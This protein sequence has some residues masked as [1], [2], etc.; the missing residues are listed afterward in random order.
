MATDDASIAARLRTRYERLAAFREP[1]LAAWREVARFAAPQADAGRFGGDPQSPRLTGDAEVVE[2]AAAFAAQRL[3]AF[4]ADTVAPYG[5]RWHELRPVGDGAESGPALQAWLDEV[6]DLLFRLRED[7]LAGFQ[8]ALESVLLDLVLYGTAVL[9]VAHEPGLGPRYEPVPVGEVVLG[10]DRAGR[11]DV[12]FRE[13]RLPARELEAAFGTVPERWRAKV[14]TAPDEPVRVLHAVVPAEPGSRWRW[15]SYHLLEG[16]IVRAAGYDTMP[17]CVVRMWLSSGEIYGRGPGILALRNMKR[18]NRVARDMVILANRQAQPPLLAVD[19]D[20]ALSLEPDALNY[21]WL[22][23]ATGR[24]RVLPL[25]LGGS[26]QVA[27][28]MHERDLRAIEEHFLLSL[29]LMAQDKA[30]T[31]TEVVQRAQERGVMLGPVVGRIQQELL[32]PMIV[33]ELAIAE[34]EGFVPPPPPGVALPPLAI[35]YETPALRQM[36]AQDGLAVVRALD[37]IA[38]IARLDPSALAAL[39]LPRAARVIAES[40]GVP[41]SVLRDEKEVRRA[42]EA[43]T[44]GALAGGGAA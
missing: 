34:A 7:P 22:D 10:A 15:A 17:Y 23:A 30:M 21:G 5:Q 24:P 3:A 44:A 27:M 16:E 9:Y 31:A 32:G 29:M 13:Y 4:L 20:E 2:Q 40:F 19:A 38:P 26:L 42:L 11:V 25:E 28:A 33:R 8:G 43:L 36:A 37:A 18:A 14:A 41:A 6:R 39:D 1:Y 35:H 12:V